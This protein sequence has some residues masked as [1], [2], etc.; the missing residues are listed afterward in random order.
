ME[1]KVS[2][3]E[4][5][6]KKPSKTGLYSIILKA[7]LFQNMALSL[8]LLGYE[9]D[10]V[11]RGNERSNQQTDKE[12]YYGLDPINPGSKLHTSLIIPFGV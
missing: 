12:D 9:K 4:K 2:A 10:N 11:M 3:P 6:E 5:R 8:P 1:R 7:K